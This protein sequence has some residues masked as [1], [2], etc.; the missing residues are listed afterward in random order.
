QLSR[1]LGRQIDIAGAAAAPRAIRGTPL[2]AGL[3]IVGGAAV[4]A[5]GPIA[6]R[7]TDLAERFRDILRG[8]LQ[9][10]DLDQAQRDVRRVVTGF[11]GSLYNLFIDWNKYVRT[12]REQ[13]TFAGQL[14]RAGGEAVTG[15]ARLDR[16]RRG[17][18]GLG[19]LFNLAGVHIGR[20]LSQFVDS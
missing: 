13:G 17:V 11:F 4:A 6:L 8:A 2:A 19:E 7:R 5:A 1:V 15:A 14:P 16:I 9:G 18:E 20:I 3:D 12:A 10:R